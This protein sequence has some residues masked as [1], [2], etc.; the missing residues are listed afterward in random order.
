[1]SNSGPVVQFSP[2]GG[3]MCSSTS[4]TGAAECQRIIAQH[5]AHWQLVWVYLPLALLVLVI[6]PS[7]IFLGRRLRATAVRYRNKQR[8]QV[9]LVFGGV[10]VM[11]AIARPLF[12]LIHL[13]AV[14]V[15]LGGL[16]LWGFGA[17]AIV[18]T[19]RPPPGRR[20]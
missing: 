10:I 14:D 4:S 19:T 12:G 13:W 2:N 11:A 18:G 3:L 9:L 1:M 15:V 17:I 8:Q 5:L 6:I 7:L 20:R 16:I